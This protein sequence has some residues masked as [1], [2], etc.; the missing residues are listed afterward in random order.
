VDNE[1]EGAIALADIIRPES[2]QALKELREMGIQ[3]IDV[4]RGL[5]GRSPVGRT[6]AR[7]G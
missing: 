1:L 3:T 4:D 7:A 6:R 2:R 5:D